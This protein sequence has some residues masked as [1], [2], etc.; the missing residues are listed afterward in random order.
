MEAV[1]TVNFSNRT[2]SWMTRKEANY[3][4]WALGSK[5]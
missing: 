1:S 2:N 3:E 5:V 4:D